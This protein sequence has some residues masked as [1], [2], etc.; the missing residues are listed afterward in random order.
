MHFSCVNN[1]KKLMHIEHQL[2]TKNCNCTKKMLFCLHT[3][4]CSAVHV[5]CMHLYLYNVYVHIPAYKIYLYRYMFTLKVEFYLG[6]SI[7]LN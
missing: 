2:S 6:Q 5:Q 3:Y 4:M 7:F 1:K